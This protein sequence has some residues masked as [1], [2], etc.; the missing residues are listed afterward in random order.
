MVNRLGFF[1]YLFLIL[2]K[3]HLLSFPCSYNSRKFLTMVL[4]SGV[5]TLSG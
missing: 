4:P 5:N 1:I 2:L 3:N